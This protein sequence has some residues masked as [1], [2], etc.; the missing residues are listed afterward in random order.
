MEPAAVRF[1]VVIPA[2][3]PERSLLQLIGALAEKPIPAIVVVDDG[4]GPEYA[5]DLP[6]GRGVWESPAGAAR[7]ES[8]QGRRAED[9]HQRCAVRLSRLAGSG[10]R[11]RRRPA[12]SGR[13]RA[14]RRQRSP[15]SRIALILGTRTFSAARSPAQPRGQ[16]RHAHRHAARWWAS[17]SRTR[18]PAC[19]ASRARCCP[20][21]CAWRRTA[22]TSS[23]TCSSPCGKQA[24]RIAEVPI[25][26]IYEP[27]NRTSHF[28][29]LI[30]SMKIYFVLLRFS[31]VSLMTAATRYAGLLP[32]LPPAWETSPHRRLSGRT[33]GRGVQLLDGAAG[34]LLLQ[35]AARFRAAEVSAAGVLER[36][37]FLCRHPTAELA[38]SYSIAPRQTVSRNAPVLCQFRHSARLYFRQEPRMAR[39]GGPGGRLDRPGPILASA[40]RAGSLAP[41]CWGSCCTASAPS[42]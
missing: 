5:R 2:Y 33:A 15:R 21:C 20:I 30:D 18:K 14:R 38:L 3:R 23:W 8:G 16:C 29:P 9:R 27:G 31:S 37:G 6:P 22:T 19:A 42:G 1:A 28:N 35:V 7:G 39:Q 10:H 12:P 36:H 32:G 17:V 34:R 40:R 41:C 24:I 13:Y 25:R 11:G 4:S 26:T